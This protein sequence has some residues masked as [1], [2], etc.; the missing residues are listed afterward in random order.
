M[1]RKISVPQAGKEKVR[2]EIPHMDPWVPVGPRGRRKEAGAWSSQ[3]SSLRE[4]GARESIG[5]VGCLLKQARELRSADPQSAFL[6]CAGG[7][8]CPECFLCPLQP[9]RKMTFEKE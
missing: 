8:H 9:A 4:K 1:A 7:I 3:E 5:R 2:T 6:P